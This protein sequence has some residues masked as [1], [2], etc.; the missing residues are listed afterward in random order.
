MQAARACGRLRGAVAGDR[1][2]FQ[3]PDEAVKYIE[4]NRIII[5]SEKY[6]DLPPFRNIMFIMCKVVFKA[7]LNMIFRQSCPL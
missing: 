3:T 4:D 6:P 5:Q 2:V 1:D 7:F